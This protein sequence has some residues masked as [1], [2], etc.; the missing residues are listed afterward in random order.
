MSAPSAEAD[1][2]TVVWTVDDVWS[3]RPEL[4]LEQAQEVLKQVKEEHE[5][6]IGPHWRL[7]ERAVWELD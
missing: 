6:P 5:A 4:T 2:I 1:S 7:I 3:V